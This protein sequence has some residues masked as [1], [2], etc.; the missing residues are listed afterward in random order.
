[1]YT[2]L[3]NRQIFDTILDFCNSMGIN[4][5]VGW[6]PRGIDKKEQLLMTFMKMRLNLPHGDLAY[7]FS[8][9]TAQVSNIVI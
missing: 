4:Y 2:G 9:Y 1:M 8:T 6:E 5:G 3:P 7:R